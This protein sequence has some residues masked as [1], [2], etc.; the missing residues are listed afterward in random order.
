M[1]P[2]IGVPSHAREGRAKVTGQARYVDDLTLPGMLHGVTVR[3]P[4]PRGLIRDIDYG[5]AIPWDDIIIVTAADI[6]GPNRRRADHRRSALPRRRPRQ[7]RR[8]A[9]RAARAPRPRAAR[10]SAAPRDDRDRAAA[11]GVHDRRGACGARDHLGHRQHRS[12]RYVV[13]RGDVDAALAERRSIV[14]GEYETGAQEQLYIEPNGMLASRSPERRRD[15]LGL[16]AVPVLHP[17]GARAAVQPARRE[18]PR[19]PDGDRRRVRR[20]GRVPV[21]HRRACGAAGVEVR[22]PGQDRLRPRRRHGR[23]R[24][25]AIRRGRGTGRRSTTDGR[26]ARDGHRLRHRRRRVLH[27]LAGRALARHDPRAGAVLLSRTSACAAARSRPTC[28]RTARSAASARRRAS[29]RSSGTWTASRPR[30][31]WR[32]TSSAGATS[33]STGQTSAVGQVMREPVD[34]AALLD[35]ALDALRL[36][37][38]ARAVRR[39]EC[40]GAACRKGIGFAAF[41]HGAGFTGSG[42]DHLASVVTVEATRR[43]AR[44][45]ADVEHRDRPGNQHDLLADRRRRARAS[46]STTIEI[47]AAGHGGRPQQ[48]ADGRVADVHGRRE[49]GRDRLRVGLRATARR[50]GLPAEDSAEDFARACRDYID[51]LGPLRASAQYQAPAGA[52]LGRRALSGRRLRHVRVGGLRRRGHRRHDDVRGARRRFRRACRK[53]GR[54]INPVLAAGPDRRRRRAGRSAGRS[55]SRSSGATAGWPTRR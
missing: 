35:R 46:M 9:G 30:S 3:S 47:V 42:E 28:R 13:S 8:G 44:A 39:R 16:D 1:P 45:R 6:P 27:A 12:R 29:S 34:M 53:S 38:Q 5:P 31:A 51:A 50:G 21:D 26:L 49:A 20:Q 17:Q 15:G 23:R 4:S 2:S 19:R 7:S 48:R 52:A 36:S 43:R 10:G 41:M 22:A 32:P 37:R 55:T 18:D 11:A 54:V 24:R 25:S 40:C 14:E 33:F